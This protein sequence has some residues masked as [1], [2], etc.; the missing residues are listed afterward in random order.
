MAS[1]TSLAARGDRGGYVVVGRQRQQSS[2]HSANTG[3]VDRVFQCSTLVLRILQKQVAQESDL[4]K[5][6]ARISTLYTAVSMI[7]GALYAGAE[8]C[9]PPGQIR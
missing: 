8:P 5:K 2:Y 7:G 9:L 6:G 3:S 1:G 4:L